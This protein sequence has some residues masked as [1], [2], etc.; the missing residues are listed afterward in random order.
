VGLNARSGRT[1]PR[2]SAALRLS[3]CEGLQR[4]SHPLGGEALREVGEI[5]ERP[6]VAEAHPFEGLRGAGDVTIRSH[7][8]GR[9]GCGRA[10]RGG[11]VDR[12]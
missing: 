3:E 5:V 7:G 6:A 9:P 10:V 12:L 4:G 8:K 1:S 11:G 2:T